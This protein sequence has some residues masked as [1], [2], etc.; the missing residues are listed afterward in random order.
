MAGYDVV[1][2]TLCANDNYYI[3]LYQHIILL[4]TYMKVQLGG[5]CEKRS[6]AVGGDIDSFAGYADIQQWWLGRLSRSMPNTLI[7]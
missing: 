5:G 6:G 4:H 1:V 3:T 7:L 2:C